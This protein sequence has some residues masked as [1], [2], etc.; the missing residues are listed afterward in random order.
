MAAEHDREVP[1]PAARSPTGGT[2]ATRGG[3]KLLRRLWSLPRPDTV[4][5]SGASYL[6]CTNTGCPWQAARL[7]AALQ[8]LVSLSRSQGGR[9][10]SPPQR[11]P[12]LILLLPLRGK[13]WHPRAAVGCW[14]GSWVPGLGGTPLS[15]WV[16]SCACA[17]GRGLLGEE[18]QL[19][20]LTSACQSLQRGE[21]AEGEA[22]RSL[23]KL[24]LGW[25]G[26]VRRC[27]AATATHSAPAGTPAPLRIRSRGLFPTLS[28]SLLL[29]LLFLL[30]PH[31]SLFLFVPGGGWEGAR[32][33][34][35]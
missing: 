8:T 18:V 33:A 17:S 21:E 13:R 19:V 2:A 16:P 31:V 11:V 32:G 30:V 27:C 9:R 23:S 28:P 15:F 12:P 4:H 29:L 3:K 35:P 7:S 22:E 34:S 26:P 5:N 14:E 25:G 20:I 1:I 10:E 6:L 24:G